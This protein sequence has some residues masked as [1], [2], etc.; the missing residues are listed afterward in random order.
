M[1]FRSIRNLISVHTVNRAVQS[2]S[3]NEN[4]IIQHAESCLQK[5]I[6]ICRNVSKDD[7]VKPLPQ[8]SNACVGSHIRHSLDHFNKILQSSEN[9]IDYDSRVRDVPWEK[10]PLLASAVANECI[11]MLQIG[12]SFSKGCTVKFMSEAVSG[13]SYLVDSTIGRELAFA[14]HHGT[15]HLYTVRLMLEGLEY[16]IFDENFG[17]ANS[18]INFKS[19]ENS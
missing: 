7:Y 14:A 11:N 18:T 17:V 16:K 2:Y 10:D 12:N 4:L 19:K 1:K 13:K 8:F 6:L 3:S 9:V 15:H 5:I